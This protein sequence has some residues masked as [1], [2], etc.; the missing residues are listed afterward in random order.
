MTAVYAVSLTGCGI[1]DPYTHPARTAPPA[2]PA[3]QPAALAPLPS[4]GAGASTSPEGAVRAFAALWGTFRPATIAVRDRALI[5]LASP[6]LA[7]QLRLARPQAELE[8]TRRAT[9]A[10]GQ[11]AAIL[12][13]QLAPGTTA[14]RRGVVVL[15]EQQIA[16]GHPAGP[17]ITTVYIV[18]VTRAA[19]RWQIS[20]WEP[21]P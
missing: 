12:S 1:N 8:A 2:A 7:T 13:S 5:G 17:A 15:S 4:L 10:P 16:A 19:R 11:Q 20:Q 3:S 9:N 21:Q 6:A 14:R 18:V